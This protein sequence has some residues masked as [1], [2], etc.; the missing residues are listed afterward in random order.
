MIIGW[1]LYEALIFVNISIYVAIQLYFEGHPAFNDKAAIEH[2]KN[3]IR[4]RNTNRM[5][6]H[7][8]L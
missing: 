7:P 4:N 2:E 8:L 3:I 1:I 5:Q 6:Q